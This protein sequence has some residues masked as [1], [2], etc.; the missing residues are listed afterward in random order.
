VTWTVIL[1]RGPKGD[2]SWVNESRRNAER[3]ADSLADLHSAKI[4][5]D[6]T[7]RTITVH[8]EEWYK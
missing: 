7:E 1:K 4:S 6:E 2:R 8:A 3:Q 5:V